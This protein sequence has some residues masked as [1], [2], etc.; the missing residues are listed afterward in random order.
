M[1]LFSLT[2][3]KFNPDKKISKSQ[4]ISDIYK[5]NTLRYP[6]D[7][8]EIDK[9][10]YMV[11]HINVQDRTSYNKNLAEGQN[12]TIFT[13]RSGV[14][15]ATGYQN[16][17]GLVNDVKNFIT[18]KT[19]NNTSGD[20]KQNVLN[21]LAKQTSLGSIGST[22]KNAIESSTSGIFK[23]IG[24]GVAGAVGGVI[25]SVG[26]L[27]NQNFARPIKRTKDTI[28]LYMPDTL[29]FQQTQGYDGLGMG[30][31]V[32]SYAAAGASML[33]NFQNAGQFGKNLSPFIA[34]ALKDVLGKGIGQGTASNLFYTMYGIVNPKMEM[35]YT[36]P[37]FRPFSFQFMF[38]PRNEKEA[39]EVQ[40][41]IERIK[42]HQAPEL[43]K[44][45]AGFFLVPPSEFDIEF[46]YNGSINPNIPKIST[47][48][49]RTIDLDYAP[50]GFTAYESPDSL[51]IPQLGKTGMPVAISMRLD[52]EETEIMTKYNFPEPIIVDDRNETRIRK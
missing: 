25:E 38:Y 40:Q 35:I 7:I 18:G 16:A 50:N 22:V 29:A 24:A 23:Q 42:F 41:I 43:D 47:C 1:A 15:R 3:I 36:K 30:D 20:L 44:G 31:E 5:T 12:P 21:E 52:F 34:N 8:G 33:K 37:Q 10:H 6:E 17:G 39:I 27:N 28:A 26:S 48:V 2:D 19:T 9:G 45:T 51:G 11:I 14:Q 46:Y 13:N 4:I 49:L 32:G